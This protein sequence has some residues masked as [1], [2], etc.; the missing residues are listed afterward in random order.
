MSTEIESRFASIESRVRAI[1]E[2]ISPP[3]VTAEPAP[4]SDAEHPPVGYR[5]EPVGGRRAPGYVWWSITEEKWD[6]RQDL[7]GFAVDSYDNIANP[8]PSSRVLKDGDV[9]VNA[10]EREK[11]GILERYARKHGP[12]SIQS[13]INELDALRAQGKEGAT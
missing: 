4:G 10:K 5:R 7:V 13:V 2:R 6:D 12:E 8:V 11:L 9:A 1:E 3:M